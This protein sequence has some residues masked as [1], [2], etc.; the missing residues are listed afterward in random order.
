MKVVSTNIAEPRTVLKNGKEVQTGIYKSPVSAGIYLGKTDVKN[1]SVIDRKFHGGIDKACYLYS[2]DHYPFWKKQYPNLD[3]H[4]GMFGENLTIEGLDES[5][6]QIGDTF[7]IGEATIQVSEPRRPCSILGIRFNDKGL[8]KKFMN[9]PYPGI[10][11]RVLE[12]GLVKSGNEMK[13]IYSTGDSLTIKDV[14]SIFS[15]NSKNMPL[16][17]MALNEPHLSEDCKN[18]IRKRFK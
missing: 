2:A 17:K 15:D 11:V 13:K 8:V 5:K 9:T 16:I 12:N 3:W 18:S 10:Y 4:L 14:Y 1:D 7:E 6:I